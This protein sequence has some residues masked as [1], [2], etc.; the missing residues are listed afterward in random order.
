MIM[1]FRL[2]SDIFEIIKNGTKDVEIRLNDE[3]RQRL[4]IGDK[5]I[6]LKRPELKEKI[7]AYVVG[8]DYYKDFNEVVDSYSMDRIFKEG[9]SKEELLE[10][11]KRFYSDEEIKKYGVVAISFKN[12]K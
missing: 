11:F 12:N 8:L 5:L 7:E 10:L 3:K 4:H 2:D 1:N 9:T 6:F